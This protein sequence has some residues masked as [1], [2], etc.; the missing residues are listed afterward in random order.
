MKCLQCEPYFFL[1]LGQTVLQCSL[2]THGYAHTMK[3]IDE[4]PMYFI[5]I[6]VCL[7]YQLVIFSDRGK[8]ELFKVDQV[9]S[10]E[11]YF[12]FTLLLTWNPS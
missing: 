10:Q 11:Y 8:S 12:P 9:S 1:F 4:N 7:S 5:W 2:S 6:N 3:N